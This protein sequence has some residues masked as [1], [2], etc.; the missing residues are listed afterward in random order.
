MDEKPRTRQKPY[1]MVGNVALVQVRGVLV[2]TAE[3]FDETT[4]NSISYAM[5][6]AVADPS[7]KG[8]A[9]MME[10]PGGEVNGMM[11]LADA[12]YS[13]RGS[14]PIVAVADEYAYSA[15]YALASS[16]DRI[17]VSRTGGVGSVGVIMMHTDITKA[18]EAA[19]IKVTTIT[20]GDRK[21]DFSPTTPLSDDAL[22]RAQHDV[23]VLGEMFVGLVAR[24]RGLDPK[25]V[26]NTEA[27]IFLGQDS[28]KVGFADAVMS[29][30]DALHELLS[31]V[32]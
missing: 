14:K 26:R 20:Y 8:I 17:T 5:A 21:A 10:S 19:G 1:D 32:S 27:G 18:L 29:P 11:D 23:D 4:Y 3:W 13:L 2:H 28:V 25:A 31:Y 9:M 24:N 12:I 15:A 30:E 6:S 7:V 16:A 22:K